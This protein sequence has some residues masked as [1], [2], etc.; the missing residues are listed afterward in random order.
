MMARAPGFLR[1]HCRTVSQTSHPKPFHKAMQALFDLCFGVVA[2]QGARFRDVGEGLRDVSGLR[3]LALDDG[4]Y[5]ELLFQER[6]QFVELD[7]ARLAE[8]DDFVAS[9][10]V[11]DD[12]HDAVDD[13][14]DVSVIATRTAVAED[15]DWLTCSDQL[16]EF[17]NR[18]V[19]TL[20]WSI[21]G[22]KAQADTA[23]PVEMRVSVTQQ[24]A[25]AFRRCVWRDGLA[26]RIVFAEWYLRVD[27]VDR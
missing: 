12:G 5:A 21:D 24:F 10:V 16:C 23:Q 4:V 22:E 2:E 7:R 27:S 18:E 13:V 25:G 3:R 26:N 20:S 8:I 11:A 6:D 14:V 1:G 15:G 19:R 9:L 17:V